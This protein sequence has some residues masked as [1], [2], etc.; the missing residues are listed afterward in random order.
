MI[1]VIAS[2]EDSVSLSDEIYVDDKRVTIRAKFVRVPYRSAFG[3]ESVKSIYAGTLQNAPIGQGDLANLPSSAFGCLISWAAPNYKYDYKY[4][5]YYIYL[6][7]NV[8]ELADN[9]YLYQI[10]RATSAAAP[11][12]SLMGMARCILP[13]SLKGSRFTQDYLQNI[14]KEHTPGISSTYSTESFELTK[15]MYQN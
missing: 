12:D 6:S 10:I 3:P 5:T 14:G 1:A 2:C 9:R 7:E 11:R 15:K 4:F 8:I 13:F